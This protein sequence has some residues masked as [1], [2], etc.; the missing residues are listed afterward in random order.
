[1][2]KIIKRTVNIEYQAKGLDKMQKE[3]SAMKINGFDSETLKQFKKE[4]QEL[5]SVLKNKGTATD[6]ETHDVIAKKYE[7]IL[8]LHRKL[9]AEIAERID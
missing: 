6:P 2:A 8:L 3:L 7:H 9:R 1:M 4:S 5:A